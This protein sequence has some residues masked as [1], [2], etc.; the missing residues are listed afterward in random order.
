MAVCPSMVVPPVKQPIRILMH[1]EAA[2]NMDQTKG[3][4]LNVHH[5]TGTGR[6][7]A[8]KHPQFDVRIYPI[9]TM[10]HLGMPGSS[11]VEVAQTPLM[12]RFGVTYLASS[13]DHQLG[14]P[15]LKRSWIG[16]YTGRLTQQSGG[17]FFWFGWFDLIDLFRGHVMCS[18]VDL[19]FP[20]GF[21]KLYMYG[22]WCVYA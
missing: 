12:A 2:I 13:W 4:S 20:L 17:R 14:I 8:L 22:V 5:S 18:S 3:T 15:P 6:S 1:R 21:Q 11:L 19:D 7:S 16:G 10:G 9:A